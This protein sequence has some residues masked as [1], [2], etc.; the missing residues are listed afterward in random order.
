MSRPNIFD[1]RLH[2]PHFIYFR[3]GIKLT[4]ENILAHFNLTKHHRV[5]EIDDATTYVII[6]D[7]GEWTMIADDWLYNLWHMPSTK[8][9]LG[10]LGKNREVFAWSVGDCDESFQFCLYRS[11]KLVRNYVVDSPNYNDQIVKVDVGEALPSETELFASDLE[12]GEKLNRLTI[13]LGIDP[14]VSRDSLR[15]Y[16]KPYSSKLSPWAGIRNF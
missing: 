5:F 3:G 16:G 10:S 13:S 15:I 11:G 1:D 7:A 8:T 12:T 6:T 2:S 14:R 4:D 9:A